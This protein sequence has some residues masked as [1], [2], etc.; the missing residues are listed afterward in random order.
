MWEHVDLLLCPGRAPSTAVQRK[1]LCIFNWLHWS[2]LAAAGMAG[3]R[4]QN[5]FGKECCSKWQKLLKKLLLNA[6]A[7]SLRPQCWR[8]KLWLPQVALSCRAMLPSGVSCASH[9]VWCWRTDH[10]L[11]LSRVSDLWT[12]RSQA[13]QSPVQHCSVCGAVY[14]IPVMYAKPSKC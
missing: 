2:M 11:L 8:C 5:L 9:T 7:T 6:W 1:Q 14:L 10:P 12:H 4:E 3:K 13:L